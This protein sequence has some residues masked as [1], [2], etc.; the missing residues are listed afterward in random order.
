MSS[1]RFSRL[2]APL[3]AGMATLTLPAVT[4]GAEGFLPVLWEGVVESPAGAPVAGSE[5]VAYARPPAA[6]LVPGQPL[7][8]VAR[9]KSGVAGRFTLRAAP[10]GALTELADPEGWVN[11]MVTATT[12]AG[13]TLAV[14]S[15]AWHDGRWV[16]DPAERYRGAEPAIAFERPS[17]LVLADEATRVPV[18]TPPEPGRCVYLDGR[19]LGKHYAQI[20]EMYMQQ[21]WS[22]FFEYTSTKSTSWQVGASYDGGVSYK[23]AGTNTFSQSVKTGG[24]D[25]KDPNTLRHK[26]YSIEL[27]FMEYRWRCGIAPGSDPYEVLTIEATR[28]TTSAHTDDGTDAP[29]CD[30]EFVIDVEPKRFFQREAKSGTVFEESFGIQ[31]GGLWVGSSKVATSESGVVQQWKNESDSRSVLCGESDYPDAFTRVKSM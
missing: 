22:G 23:Q 18:K 26:V 8:E 13:T 30:V 3:A 20:G 24:D 10:S 19:S 2:I 12:P 28:W 5:V 11:V 14:D 6:Q 4:V 21:G 31:A 7:P 29:G 16:T 15:V 27:I 9:T 17:A 25:L 1:F